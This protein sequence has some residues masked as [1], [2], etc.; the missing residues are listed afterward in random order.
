M[1]A[2]ETVIGLEVHAQ[3]STRSK[4]FSTA[5]T[6]YGAEPNRQAC[7][8]DLALPGVLP[9]VNRE[10]IRMAV[11][12][13]LAVGA[14]IRSPCVFERKNYFYP[15]LPRGYQISQY[16]AP[17]VEGGSV[18]IELPDGARRRIAL[19]RA[20]LEEDA[21]KLLHEGLGGESAVDLNRAGVPLMEIVSEPRMRSPEEASAYMRALHGIVTFL[22]ICDGNMEQGS[23]RCDANV[24]VRRAGESELGVKVEIKNINSF[25]FVERALRYERERQIDALESGRTIIQETRQYDPESDRTRPMRVKERA[26]DYRYFPDPD[27]LPVVVDEAM[28]EELARSIPEL[29]QSRKDRWIERHALDPDLAAALARSRNWAD[30]FEAVVEAG[31]RATA[32]ARWITGEVF[33]RMR[34]SSAGAAEP[35]VSAE[36]LA[37]LLRRVDDRTVSSS[38]AKEVLDAMWR[39]EGEAEEIIEARGLRQIGE[40]ADLDQWIRQV[41]ERHPD[42]VARYRAGED[43]L[44][45]FFVGQAMRM[46]GGKADPRRVSERLRETLRPNPDDGTRGE[47]E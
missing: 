18:E 41:I 11:R 38:A 36:S 20:H 30:Y 40:G 2:W 39:G 14:E 44:L 17:I 24:S 15:D 42:E 34:K 28:R 25:R 45:G 43:R 12:F 22:E 13:G 23:F 9:T 5:S 7:G 16:E 8:I 26:D 3:L 4:L 37:R 47:G 1:S 6:R 29:P 19:T 10:A 31:A 27:L 32:A 35:P 33:A 46:S 21:G